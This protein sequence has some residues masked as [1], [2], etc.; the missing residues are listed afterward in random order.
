MPFHEAA[1]LSL[2]RTSR[3]PQ[4]GINLVDFNPFSGSFAGVVVAENTFDASGSFI[5]IGIPMG[6]STW[7]SQNSTTYSTGAT[8]R[9]NLFT[10][11]GTGAF[12]WAIAVAGHADAVISGNSFRNANFGGM[13]SSGCVPFTTLHGPDRALTAPRLSL[14][15]CTAAKPPTPQPLIFD[16]SITRNI[17][18]NQQ[19]FTAQTIQLLICEAPSTTYAMKGFTATY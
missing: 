6:L 15:R 1:T 7:G 2:T 17:A 14:F 3:K 9:D 11:S 10:S 16:P 12:G 13:P 4:G 8:V 5:K 19:G 18:Y